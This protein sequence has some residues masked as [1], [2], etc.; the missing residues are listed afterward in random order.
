LRWPARIWVGLVLG[1]LLAAGLCAVATV[2]AQEAETT[3]GSGLSEAQLIERSLR[4]EDGVMGSPAIAAERIQALAAEV[5]EDSPL[6][7]EFLGLAGRWFASA[8]MDDAARAMVEQLR[9]RAQQRGDGSDL[10]A[11]LIELR[12][13]A[14]A[15]GAARQLPGMQALRERIDAELSVRERLR[16]WNN[17]A[18]T[19]SAAGE[20]GQAIAAYQTASELADQVEYPPWRATVRTG[21]AGA[22]AAF[23]QQRR[24][25]RMAR[26]AVEIAKSSG[27]HLLISEAYTT[28]GV[29]LDEGG[30]SE[31]LLTAMKLAI[32]HA[33]LAGNGASLS[34]LLGNV[35]H[36]HLVNHD[37]P[38]AEQVS[39]EALELAE[40]EEDRRGVAL[41]QA[42][43]GL[44]RIGL[45]RVEEGKV[46]VRQSLEFDEARGQRNEVLLTY[47]ELGAA[48]ERA[49]DLKGAI[50][51]LH[52]AR[53]LQ[54]EIFR[55]DQQRAVLGLQEEVEARRREKAIEQL[56]AEN[57][58]KA[59]QVERNRL[60]Q[61]VWRLLSL[62]LLLA[63]GL[64]GY[65]VRRLRSSNRRL[66]G[67]NAQL[68]LQSERDPLTGLANRR[69]VQAAVQLAGGERAYTG[70]LL[71]IDLDHF[72]SINDRYGHA[73]G[74]RVL[75][76]VGRRLRS[77]CRGGDLAARW[78]GEE[79][80]LVLDWLAP[81]DATHLAQR[82][83]AELSRPVETEAMEVPISA[84]I[85]FAGVPLP[86]AAARLSFEQALR[87]VD[88]ALYLAK[89]RGRNRACGIAWMRDA[90]P[91]AFESSVAD[92]EHAEAMG[93][94]GLQLVLG[95]SE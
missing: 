4:I 7:R 51:A 83:L 47:Q 42:N 25:E 53:R 67:V 10:L 87:L 90:S 85:G 20:L 95:E 61:W 89:L 22:L 39:L 59:A 50:E 5:P 86:P 72:K 41:A 84:S 12:I 94:V 91:E 46:L 8:Q 43:L 24:A 68:R 30:D 52:A 36:Y 11:A 55:E 27:D 40:R 65:G 19:L 15:H 60:Q 73:M 79:F 70:T 63:L 17:L 14:I 16:F 21:M 75:V 45:G 13:E 6:R 64:L 54:D 23:G 81:E 76:E 1:G 93:R 77:I 9:R 29:V 28:L 34:I 44:S 58:R 71:L 74:D 69:H 31:G 18:G 49:G 82:L 26:E 66:A 56:N 32:E 62:L 33:R 78:G 48:L 35:A 2:S 92:L 38:Q 80:L 3:T 37:Y 88:A 57:A